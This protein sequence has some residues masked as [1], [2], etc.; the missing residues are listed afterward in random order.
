M[1]FPSLVRLMWRQLVLG[2]SGPPGRRR[3]PTGAFGPSAWELEPRQLLSAI[4]SAPPV[5]P[6]IDGT[7]HNVAHPDWG[8]TGSDL[9]R[10]AP[11]MYED[12][13]LSPAGSDR[14]SA[15]EVSATIFNQAE[16]TESA[17]GLTN[18]VY[19]WGQFIDHDMDLTTGASPT[20]AF[21]IQVPK[22]DPF[23]DPAGT[24]TKTISLSRSKWDP[25]T[26]KSGANPRQQVNDI[27]A[28]LD[29]SMIYGSD[30]TTANALRTFQGGKLKTSDGNLLPIDPATAGSSNPQF[31]AGDI[32]ANENI[33][34]TSL[35]V[36]FMREH[37]RL[38]DQ[39]A[40]SNP[41]LTDEQIY[42]QARL[43]VIAEIQAITYNEF[44]PTLIGQGAIDPYSG[45]KPD[46]NPGIANEFST[47]AFRVGHTMV[48]DDVDFLDDQ[49]NEIREPVLLQD[50]FFNPNLIRENGIDP[51]MK[52][53]FSDR[54]EEID[55]QVVNSL[56]NFLF[57]PPGSGGLDLASLN[58]QRGR[59]HGLADYNTVR[60]SYGLPKVGSFAEITADPELQAKL[61][62]LYGSVD[63]I[64][65]WVGGLAEDH[66]PGSNVGE[67][68]TTI[69]AD[70]F[71]RLRDGDRY[72]FE[73]VFKEQ[74]LRAIKSTTL[75]DIIKRNTNLRNVQQNVFLF[76]TSIQGNVFADGNRDGRMLP[77]ERGLAGRTVELLDSTGAVVGTT[78]TGRDGT[79]LFEDMPLGQYR[80][81][82]V[83]P[84]G[85]VATTPARLITI[86][87][88]M[89][90]RGVN[91]GE[92]AGKSNRPQNQPAQ[93]ARNLSVWGT[94]L[95]Q[96]STRGGRR[97]GPSQMLLRPDNASTN[98]A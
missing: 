25:A 68:F 69:I 60:E 36:L 95:G 13:I 50:A 16:E 14:P 15:R 4:V 56:Q 5:G 75:A 86:N 62:D 1:T 84:Q 73:N 72:Y 11:A 85:A 7:G 21:P 48:G 51:I 46:V 94:L 10:T 89:T 17:S 61:E 77:P 47:A 37:N 30:Q 2:L 8:S 23:F 19:A 64:D 81:R 87:Q 29:G 92:A 6:S 40:K 45:Y 65:L 78:V 22:G 98:Q 9:L 90:V 26:G 58:I 54:A 31:L 27:T 71:T 39:I 18:L 32:R 52:Y 20:E 66:A 35:Q 74:E 67:T 28:F 79:Y 76:Q 49:G 80:V 55:T 63:N 57:G 24:G 97:S 93:P 82:E 42:Q 34:L 83:L 44:L 41:K 53:L 43:R 88:P 59:D 96:I 12:G 3:R 38:A 70:Q 91:L 33:E